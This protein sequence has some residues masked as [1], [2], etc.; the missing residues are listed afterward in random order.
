MIPISQ[1]HA[2]SMR[3][4]T[5]STVSAEVRCASSK[6]RVPNQLIIWSAMIRHGES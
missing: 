3:I 6:S 1:A 2:P 5:M 4:V